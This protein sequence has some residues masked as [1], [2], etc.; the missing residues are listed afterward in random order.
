MIIKSTIAALA[1]TVGLALCSSD[2]VT[3]SSCGRAEVQAIVSCHT[4]AL[5]PGQVRRAQRR[6]ARAARRQSR[7]NARA[8][9]HQVANCAAPRGCGVAVIV[10]Q[11]RVE[12]GS[13][14]CE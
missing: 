2:T 8:A 3:A 1:I 5:R 12:V 4:V 13:A 11:V 7:L 10:P 14:C 9:C 6:D